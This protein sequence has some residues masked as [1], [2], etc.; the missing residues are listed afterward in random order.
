MENIT[1][2]EEE[3]IKNKDWK[4]LAELSAKQLKAK[5]KEKKKISKRKMNT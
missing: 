2:S 4:G 5:R 1:T 3:Y